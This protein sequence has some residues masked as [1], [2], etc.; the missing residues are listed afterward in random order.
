M[1][2][3]CLDNLPQMLKMEYI[4]TATSINY[5]RK[6]QGTL[7]AGKVGNPKQRNKADYML[8]GTHVSKHTDSSSV[9][10]LH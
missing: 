3:G 1:N 6:I 5:L 9:A 7:E 4:H 8:S 2:A 10:G